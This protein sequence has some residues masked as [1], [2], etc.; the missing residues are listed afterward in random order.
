MKHLL[1]L[2]VFSTNLIYAQDWITTVTQQSDLINEISVVDDNVIWVMDQGDN[3][4]GFSISTDG[5]LNWIKKSFPQYFTDN[6]F[7][8][9]GVLSAVSETT[10][11]IIV[12]GADNASLVGLYKT[13][14]S[15]DTWQRENAIF[16]TGF[17]FP[18]QVHFWNANRGFAMGDGLELYVYLDGS[19]YNQSSTITSVGTW[20]LNSSNFLKIVGNSAYFLTGSGTIVKTN[21][22]GLNWSEII[23]PFNSQANVNFDFKDDLNG[24]IVYNDFTTNQLY[25]TTDGGQNWF[26]Q[27]SNINNLQSIIKYA[28]S[29]GKYYSLGRDNVN[30]FKNSYSEDN[31][32]TW[33]TIQEFDGLLLG[34]IA[35]STTGKVFI[36]GSPNI[37]YQNPPDY[38]SHPDYNALVDFYNATQGD[39]WTDNTN[40]LDT[41]APIS[42]WYGITETNGRVTGINLNSNNLSGTIPES[43]GNLTNLETFSIRI[44]NIYGSL[45]ESIVNLTK[46]Q[47]FDINSN[48]IVGIIAPW[49]GI[50]T[51]LW[52]Y[53]IG[54]NF[55][56][57]NIPEDLTTLDN[58][59]YIYLQNNSLTGDLPS[60]NIPQSLNVF[61]ASNNNLSGAVPNFS[62]I[63]TLTFLNISGNR[64]EFADLEPN[65]SDINN[66]L[67]ANFIY[68]PQQLVDTPL[69]EVLLIGESSTLI[70]NVSGTQNSYAWSRINADGS[71]GG[72]IGNNSTINITINTVDDYK[73]YYFYEATSAIVPGLILKSNFFKFSESPTTHPDYDAL[74]AIYSAL[75]G[76]DWDITKPI[77]NWSSNFDIG[78]DPV[79]DRVTSLGITGNAPITGTIPPEIG[80][81]TE[82]TYLDLLQE[83]LSG[84]IPIEIWSLT[85]LKTLFLGAQASKQLLLTNGI[86]PEIANLQDLEWLNLTQ[87]PLTQP[88]QPELF[89]LPNLI[90]LR[91]VECGLTGSLPKELAQISDLLASGNEFEGA[92]PQEF[93]DAV[94]N[95][96]LNITNN[97]FNFANL[98][99][100][101][102]ANNYQNL[103]YSPQRTKDIVQNLDFVPGSNIVLNIDDTSLGK[104]TSS[105]GIGDE[106]Q[107]YKD[108]ISINGA[109]A[110]SHTIN[111]AQE[112]DSGVYYCIITNPLLA[113]L[114]IQRANIIL[115][116]DS[117]LSID[118]YIS[119]NI[120]I[121]PNPT[122]NVLNIKLNNTEIKKAQLFDVNGKQIL[123]MKLQS[124]LTVV[125]ISNLNSGIYLLKIESVKNTFIKRI[126]KE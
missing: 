50:Y 112:S 13:T 23:T 93:L 64:F 20:S 48:S 75:N 34:D 16:N 9:L 28:P 111:N 44:N 74:I 77:H 38:S 89:N 97:Y 109:N 100:L 118:D 65:Y 2:L 52:Y 37:Y 72:P 104:A 76:I 69:N 26:L 78:F 21:D 70:T 15:G 90:R 47:Y 124:E 79:T 8:A 119:K 41:T 31:G 24:I 83:D 62:F 92:I 59:Q 5:G 98:E 66:S 114:I 68:S 19:W 88:L 36:G 95:T 67:G 71:E 108:G 18:N 82:L 43:F 22:Q 105:K 27:G 53:D 35:Y 1:L 125:D 102:Q 57:G 117:A 33:T 86:P 113:D 17:S 99:P 7:Y 126:V 116:I 56:S 107:W 51:D 84:E 30:G 3:P 85:K 94:G 96:N 12:S 103:Y 121:Y 46:I 6:N 91:I 32:V 25:R 73:W 63:T 45:P 120:K 122:T 123:D 110:I 61:D 58:L 60:N 101:A 115:N 87:I 10:A 106:Y 40:W 11:Y 81:L 39:N 49:I 4:N 29:H 42:T 55:I 80:D 14:D 54:W